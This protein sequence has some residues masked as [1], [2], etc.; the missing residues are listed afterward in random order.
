MR[1]FIRSVFIAFFSLCG[2]AQ[3]QVKQ[4]AVTFNQLPHQ[5]PLAEVSLNR[6]NI[7]TVKLLNLIEEYRVPVVGFV[8]EKEL[9]KLREFDRRFALLNLWIQ[10]GVELGNGGYANIALADT[11]LQ[12]FETQLVLGNNITGLLMS[13]SGKRVRYVRFPGNYIGATPAERAEI[14]AFAEELKLTQVPVTMDF[15][16]QDFVAAY[17]FYKSKGNNKKMQEVADAYLAHADQCMQ[18]YEA[19][20]VRVWQRQVAHVLQLNVG[21]LQADVFGR[22]VRVIKAR[23][24]TLVPLDKAL[25]DEAY[26]TS[27]NDYSGPDGVT[28]LYRW[29]N[30]KGVNAQP[31]DAPPV[32][33]IARKS[34]KGSRGVN[35]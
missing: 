1:I 2:T 15:N 12:G 34:D 4:M 14:I 9:L 20:S 7:A 23:G 33:A 35:P 6:I 31:A 21:E 18:Y 10:N 26:A 25:A 5:W 24:Y 28:W 13:E 27:L 11:S 22:L 32:P 19:L 29:A 16:D 3:A 8:N 30:L 17:S